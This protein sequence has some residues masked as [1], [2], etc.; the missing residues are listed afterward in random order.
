MRQTLVLMSF[1]ASHLMWQTLVL[2]SFLAIVIIFFASRQ[3]VV[4]FHDAATNRDDLVGINVKGGI[5]K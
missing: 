5:V 3:V 1:F 4:L 2:M